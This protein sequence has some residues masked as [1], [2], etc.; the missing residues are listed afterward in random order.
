VPIGAQPDWHCML[1]VTATVQTGPFIAPM[2]GTS[3]EDERALPPPRCTTRGVWRQM[4]AKKAPSGNAVAQLG[5]WA[6]EKA[7]P[8]QWF[9]NIAGA[10]SER[11]PDACP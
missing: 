5:Y 10:F 8:A 6:P 9:A 7:K 11:L 1:T 2:D 3:C 4:I